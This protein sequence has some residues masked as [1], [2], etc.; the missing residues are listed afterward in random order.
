MWT[1]LLNTLKRFEGKNPLLFSRCFDI[2]HPDAAFPD[3]QTTFQE[4]P[5]FFLEL[6]TEFFDSF[7]LPDKVVKKSS[8]NI[9][10]NNNYDPDKACMPFIRFLS[11]AVNK[12][13]GPEDKR[14]KKNKSEY[15]ENKGITWHL[16]VSCFGFFLIRSF[17]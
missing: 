12:G 4:S 8:Y 14:Q 9:R 13:P 5:E 3:L 11:Q 1:T 17:S 16:T 7:R 15:N 2:L 6:S 10:K